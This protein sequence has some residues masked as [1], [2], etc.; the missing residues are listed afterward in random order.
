MIITNSLNMTADQAQYNSKLRTFTLTF[1]LSHSHGQFSDTHQ[2][3]SLSQSESHS[4][5]LTQSVK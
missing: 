2:S 1:V 3:E 5:S 4:D